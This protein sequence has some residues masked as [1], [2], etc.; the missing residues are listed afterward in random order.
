[1]DPLTLVLAAALVVLPALAASLLPACRAAST[2]PVE[3]L[4]GE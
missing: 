4:R 1:L 3:A 2:N